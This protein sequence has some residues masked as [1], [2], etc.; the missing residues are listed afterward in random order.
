MCLASNIWEILAIWVLKVCW[1]G[2]LKSQIL[3]LFSVLRVCFHSLLS[4][5][6]ENAWSRNLVLSS[7]QW[8][9]PTLLQLSCNF[10]AA[11]LQLFGPRVRG[12]V[13][14]GLPPPLFCQYSELFSVFEVCRLSKRSE[15][16]GLS[17]F[18]GN[19][20]DLGAQS[21]SSWGFGIADSRAV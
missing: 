11:F 12:S 16:Q 4:I 19:R 15:P 21:V 3:V 2:A 1:F 9:A 18:K 8:G 14:R 20:D 7:V 6:I 5:G 10:P 17:G 13:E